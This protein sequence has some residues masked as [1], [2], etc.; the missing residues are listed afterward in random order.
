M[1]LKRDGSFLCASCE[2]QDEFLAV[3]PHAER[4]DTTVRLR[5]GIDAEIV[6]QVTA[7][8]RKLP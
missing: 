3:H 2:L 8:L 4:P 1:I 6:G 5:N 7:I